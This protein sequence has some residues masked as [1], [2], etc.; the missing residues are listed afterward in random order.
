M[1]DQSHNHRVPVCPWG[2]FSRREFLKFLAVASV[3]P[4]SMFD[5]DISKTPKNLVR[6]PTSVQL[7]KRYEY[8]E[9]RSILIRM[10]DEI[11]GVR[12]LVKNKFITAKVNL[13]NVGE[14]NVNGIPLELT[15]VTHP[16][17]AMALGSILVEFGAKQITFCDQLPYR[18]NHDASFAHYGYFIKDFASAMDGRVKFEN[19]RNK[20]SYKNYELVK[21]P[22]G[23]LTNAWE[24]NP[25]YAKTDV[26]ISLGKLKSHVSGGVSL[27]MK[28]LFGVPPSS[29]YGDDLN[30]EPDENATAYRSNTMHNSDR[31]PLTSVTTFLGKTQK[32]EHGYNVPRFIVDL[33]SAFPVSLTVIDGISTIQ[34]GE[35]WWLG[36]MVA[37]TCPGLLIAGRNPVC[38]DS[39]AAAIM[40]F[41]P[42]AKSL[43]SPFSNG[44]NYLQ[45]ARSIGLG[46]NRIQNLDVC[47]IGLE[48][49]RFQFTPTYTRVKRV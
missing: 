3:L 4:A 45:L 41:D 35:G 13:V 48:K 44:T 7:C 16:I 42:D 40:G 30:Q 43:T 25:I 12:D 18:E 6:T 32:G 11:G 34:N 1:S 29:L 23:I 46:E 49:A 19:T 38:T 14:E 24:V 21:V 9:I 26:L 47:G 33:N 20:G 17:A 31:M 22:G 39:V 28:N 27:G 8:K 36:S 10:L 5:V 2:V 15:V 37:P